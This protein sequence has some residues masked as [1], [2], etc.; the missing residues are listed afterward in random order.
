MRRRDLIGGVLALALWGALL[1]GAPA[2]GTRLRGRAPMAGS[3]RLLYHDDDGGIY[4][5]DDDV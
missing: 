3:R 2:G 4:G 1:A 5:D